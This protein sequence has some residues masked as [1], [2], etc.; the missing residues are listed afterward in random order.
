MD[1]FL[2]SVAGDAFPYL[3]VAEPGRVSTERQSARPFRVAR[4]TERHRDRIRQS[5]SL[6]VTRIS[7]AV[8]GV[9]TEG[10]RIL[11]VEMARAPAQHLPQVDSARLEADQLSGRRI[12]RP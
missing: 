1:L 9:T 11:F 12:D 2:W 8:D 6:R 7:D 10:R 3:R 5:H 4:L